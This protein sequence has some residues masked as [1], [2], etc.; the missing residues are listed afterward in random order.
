MAGTSFPEAADAS[1]P[2]MNCLRVEFSILHPVFQFRLYSLPVC[3]S[4]LYEDAAPVQNSHD[5]E[6]EQVK[7]DGENKRTTHWARVRCKRIAD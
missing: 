5:T 1:V 3:A 7:Q 6:P 4:D 2:S